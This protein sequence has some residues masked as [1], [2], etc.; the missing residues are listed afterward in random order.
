[1]ALRRTLPG[2][3]VRHSQIAPR[4]DAAK[5]LKLIDMRFLGADSGLSH[6]Q[7]VALAWALV[8]VPFL[9]WGELAENI[10]KHQSFGFDDPI[11]LWLHGH[12][13][14]S[15]DRVMLAL[16]LVG[17]YP[18]LFGAG[19]LL[20]FFLLSSQRRNAIFVALCIG[21]VSALNVSAKL[22]F[23]RARP[24]L[25]V[26]LA[27]EPDYSFPSGH[28]MLSSAF[29]AMIVAL[30]WRATRS[31]PR[32]GLWRLFS[33]FIGLIFVIAVGLSRMYL[34]VHYPSDILAG[35]LASC[36]W[37]GLVRIVMGD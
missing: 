8:L 35:W 21:G 2:E 11:L 26:S 24:E 5:C 29:T 23:Q 20:L 30:V 18:L 22:L 13:N 14:A 31:S 28:A 3:N 12:S 1:M 37:I 7:R 15:R 36:A 33:A 6:W 17:G 34:G 27:P 10:W 25:W 4:S 16:S 19:A 9:I 32:A